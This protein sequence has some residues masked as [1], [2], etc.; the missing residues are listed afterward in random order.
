[1]STITHA[2]YFGTKLSKCVVFIITS[3]LILTLSLSFTSH[4]H[5][6]PASDT[7]SLDALL[8][9]VGGSLVESGRSNWTEATAELNQFEGQWKMIRKDTTEAKAIDKGLS[10]AKAA[11]QHQD[12]ALSNSTLSSLA[13]QVNTYVDQQQQ[14]G[15]SREHAVTS[16]KTLLKLVQQTSTDLTEHKS[17]QALNSYKLLTGRW[18]TVESPIRQDNFSVYSQLE[19]KLSVIR[20]SLQAE[21]A[22]LDQAS[23]N[24]AE[25]S[26]LLQDYI[27]GKLS[28]NVT[29][30]T[31]TTGRKLSDAL[32]ILKK[33]QSSIAAGQAATASDT[34]AEFITLWPSVEGEV[35][36]SSPTLYNSTENQMAEVQGYLI[37]SP[38]N[39]KQ[40]NEVI[41]GMIQSL[42]P[43]TATTSYTAWD[44]ALVLLREG[45]EAILV[46]AALLAFVKRSDNK[47]AR[48]YVWA[49]ASTGLVLSGV[50][51]LIL[52]YTIS[53]AAS[54]SAR[55]LIEGITGIV[56]VIMMLTIGHWLHSKANTKAWNQYIS[57]QVG[58][59]IA[60][61]SH[62]SLF[63][64]AGI[65]ILREGSE[66]AIFYIGMAPAI[67][68]V[69]FAIGI[70]GALAALIVL[71]FFIIYFSARLPLRPFFLTATILIYYLVLRF[72]GESIH[73]LQ[74]AGKIS[75]HS[76][77]WLPAIRS[78][79]AYP[80]LETYAAQ[81]IVLL[82]IVWTLTRKKPTS[83]S[84]TA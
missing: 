31:N 36:I 71:A 57:D 61:G 20:I 15:S 25:L 14:A 53:Q 55:E 80:T 3:V 29:P 63:A 19:N 65:A 66:T 76:E 52:T 49:G 40:A 13:K 27:S 16:A 23:K 30:D 79:G 28:S 54:G 83:Q 51:A 59:A 37:S 62:W 82:F 41:G 22:R 18:K 38:P 60:R 69:Q 17:E 67:D 74:I 84:A 34:M 7:K 58:G 26:T 1:M 73:S 44:A 12:A 11:L 24:L 56:A 42:A 21:P 8:P 6:D 70:I 5:A 47:R 72:I 35:S 33:V 46:L 68:P 50:L 9:L 32:V 39:L 64:L 75:A 81:I 2:S 77:S 78:L 45:L 48:G 4:T 10:D 43:L